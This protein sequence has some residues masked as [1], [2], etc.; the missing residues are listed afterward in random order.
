MGL[1]RPARIALAYPSPYR[2]AMSSLGYQTIYRT[3]HE[4]GLC[5][6]RAFLPD[7]WGRNALPWPR[8]P[9]T[10]LTYEGRAPLSAHRVVALSVAYELELAGVVRL[11]EAAGIPPLARDRHERDPIVVAGGP[12]TF[13]NPYPLLPLVDVLVLGEAEHLVADLFDDLLRAPTRSSALAAAERCSHAV[14]GEVGAPYGAD[15]PPVGKAPRAMLPARSAIVTSDTELADMF[16]VEPERGCS[17]PCT[18][19]VMRRT[20]NGGMRLFSADEV[21]ATIPEDARRVGLVGAAV[22][23]HPQLEAIVHRIVEGGRGIGISSLRADRLTPSL[24]A[25][26]RRGGY[27]Q[28]TVASDGISERMRTLL[29]RRIR[30]DHL[31]TAAERV[32][33]AG[34]SGLKV[35]EMIG[36]PEET[37]DDVTELI[38]FA[39]ELASIVPLTLTFSTFVPKRNT[40]LD[41]APF[42]G[43]AASRARLDRIRRALRGTVSIR[44]QSPKWAH[45]EYL[46]ARAGSEGGHAAVAAVRAGGGY[47]AWCAAFEGL[48]PGTRPLRYGD[49]EAWARRKGLAALRVPARLRKTPRRS[50][51]RSAAVDTS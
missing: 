47:R 20:T 32:A 28:I 9:T 27:R 29:D 45:V 26:L 21:L 4:A 43:V 18:F 41:G 51:G 42:V 10:I 24:L 22:T 30:E 23:D 48:P 37:D 49:E 12:L 8:P 38:E 16:L 35:Y 11:L 13:S 7:G 6:H 36:A 33:E 1:G 31:R 19:C 17:R 3:L 40:P 46:L 44:P 5:T 2:V 39:R 34:F 15:L 14:L 25:A 50:E